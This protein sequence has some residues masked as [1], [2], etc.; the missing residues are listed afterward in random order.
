MKL[1]H[2]DEE[3]SRQLDSAD[4]NMR[5]QVIL[6]VNLPQAQ[7]VD[8]T[9]APTHDERK[10]DYEL[11]HSASKAIEDRFRSVGLSSPSVLPQLGIALISGTSQQIR[12]AIQFEEV[13]GAVPDRGLFSI[14]DQPRKE[15][16]A[17]RVEDSRKRKSPPQIDG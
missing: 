7:P 2:I 17:A 6:T 1:D 9:R 15:G 14:N 11:R 8:H 5:L 4:P 12:R 10:A 16:H 13:I 3:L